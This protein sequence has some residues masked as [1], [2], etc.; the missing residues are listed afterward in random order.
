MKEIPTSETIDATSTAEDVD[1]SQSP[2]D[3]EA[4]EPLAT[5]DIS[6]PVGGK[7]RKKKSGKNGDRSSRIETESKPI[8]T[9]KKYQ[10]LL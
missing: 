9:E 1:D 4:S 2:P 7:K 10:H 3:A 6:R 8:V 5:G